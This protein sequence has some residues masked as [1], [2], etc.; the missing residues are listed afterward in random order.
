M[1]TILQLTSLSGNVVEGAKW[2]AQFSISPNE[3]HELTLTF[4]SSD[5]SIISFLSKNERRGILLYGDKNEGYVIAIRCDI[6]NVKHMFDVNAQDST[7][8]IL[9]SPN[10]RTSEQVL[11]Y[12]I[13]PHLC[14]ANFLQSVRA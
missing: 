3:S 13:D 6:K 5:E 9:I 7:S 12:L 1:N 10:N 8:M 11:L 4:N 14:A 2:E